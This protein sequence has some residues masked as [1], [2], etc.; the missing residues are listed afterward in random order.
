MET[1]ANKNKTLLVSDR[2]FAKLY[3]LL[4][5]YLQPEFCV[6]VHACQFINSLKGYNGNNI[7]LTINCHVVRKIMALKAIC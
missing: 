1:S 6:Q 2:P 7:F 5:H 4:H 3:F